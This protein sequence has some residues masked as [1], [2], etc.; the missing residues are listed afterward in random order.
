MTVLNDICEKKKA[1]VAHM[2]KLRSIDDLI[3]QTPK[4]LPRFKFEEALEQNKK[5]NKR[6]IIAEIKKA[7]PSQGII[8]EDFDPIEIAKNYETAGAT[9][10]SCLTDEPYF[11][12]KDVYLKDVLAVT[13]LPVLRKDFMVDLYQIYESRYLGADCILI[14]MAAIDDALAKDMYTLATDLGMTALFEVHNKEELERAL[15]L[16]PRIIGV[17]NRNLKTLD[18]SLETSYSLI[19]SIPKGIIRISESGI[20]TAQDIKILSEKGFDGY[21]IGESLMNKDNEALNTLVNA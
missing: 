21:L 5:N 9:C 17:N 8:R 7:S 11:Q 14:I 4:D 6:S 16:S 10:I 15:P 18:V 2:K 3:S 19:S 1:H 13:S 12:G 20:K